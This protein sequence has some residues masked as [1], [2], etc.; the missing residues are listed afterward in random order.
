MTVAAMN[1]RLNSHLMRPRRGMSSILMLALIVTLGT[2][3]VHAAG[4]VSA[5]SGDGTRALAQQR[6]AAAAQAGLEWGRLRA[7]AMPAPLCAP[8]QNITT[9]PGTLQP[10]TVSVRCTAGP[11]LSDGG[12]PLRRYEVQA[13]ACNLPAGGA[14]P[15]AGTTS[16]DYVQRTGRHVVHR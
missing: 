14:C 8:L 6:A 12:T 3:A 16:P 9:L 10:Y 2:L 1:T 11:V 7:S 15:N 5:A 4:L 13:T